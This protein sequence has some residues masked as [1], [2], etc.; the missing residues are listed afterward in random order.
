M[1]AEDKG[2][3]NYLVFTHTPLSP[4][5]RPYY[6]IY[7]PEIDGYQMKIESSVYHNLPIS[8]LWAECRGLSEALDVAG[9]SPAYRQ[10]RW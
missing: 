8:D 1:R 4:L 5:A 7:G 3:S 6:N 10:W 2:L 9:S